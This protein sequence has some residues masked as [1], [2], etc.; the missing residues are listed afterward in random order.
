[1]NEMDTSGV[2]GCVRV[3]VRVNNKQLKL[4]HTIIKNFITCII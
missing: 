3:C 1:M 4:S 2:C